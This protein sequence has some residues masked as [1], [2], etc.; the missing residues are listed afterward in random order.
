MVVLSPDERKWQAENDARTLA[1]AEQIKEDKTRLEAAQSAAKRMLEEEE[2][3][4]RAMR[5]VARKKR[6]TGSTGVRKNVEAKKREKP[7]KY[8][9]NIG[10]RI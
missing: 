8:K 6:A 10:K 3:R 1:E 9:F 5:K 4:T 2:E 7:K